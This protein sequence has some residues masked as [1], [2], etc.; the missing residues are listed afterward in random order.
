MPTSKK[1]TS[2]KSQQK[3]K[4]KR[5]AAMRATFVASRDQYLARRPHRSFQRTRRRDYAR[6]LKMPG[7]IAFTSHVRKTLWSNRK[8]FLL[9]CLVYAIV[10]G[11]LVGLAS[12]DTYTALRSG[13]EQ[14]S[15]DLFSGNWGEIGK[16]GLL[17]LSTLSGGISN[18]LTDVQ[19]LYT[20]LIILMTWLTTVW[21]LRNILAGHKVKLRDGLY[22]S[23][24][25]LFSTFLVGVVLTLQLLPFALAIIG[26]SAATSTG[27]IAGG[28]VEAMLFWIAAGLLALL[29][30]YWIT[31]TFIALV[32]VTL[33]GM[34]PFAA[35]RTAGDL[36]I[37]R[38]IRILLRL[39]WLA[40]GVALGWVIVI[41]PVILF[42][43]WL[44]G[45][46]PASEWVPI[47]PVAFLVLG[48]VSVVW[49]ASY[50]YLLYRR[51]VED[52]SAPA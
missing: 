46:W 20:G 3:P 13:I 15:G 25:P 5:F 33:P 44:K 39:L 2:Q 10:T 28:G 7:Y 14:T 8:Q 51:I 9:L 12:Q 29:S 22:N 32:V 26:Y 37:G 52:D 40:V 4:R 36:V 48:A 45:L 16:A 6:S 50:I 17:F 42:D 19:Q 23:T 31:S 35:L 27:L 18:N 11:V 30:L 21:L 49:A 1:R 34:Y 41:I 43:G 38:R 47:I 24:A